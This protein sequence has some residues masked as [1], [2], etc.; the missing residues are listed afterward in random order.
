MKKSQIFTLRLFSLLLAI[1][2]PLLT[3]ASCSAEA[4]SNDQINGLRPG[5][6]Y[7]SSDPSVKPE[8]GEADEE[9]FT[10]M[11]GMIEPSA[12]SDPN[13]IFKEN[14]F[15]KVAQSPISTFSSD[16]DTAS[17]AYF[18]KLVNS[19]YSFSALTQDFGYSIRTEE[20]LNYFTYHYTEPKEG[21]LFGIHTEIAPCPWN[22]DNYLMMINFT[23]KTV[24]AN[25]NGNNLVFLID[26]SGSMYSSD[27]L[28]L[29]K[30]A[31]T[32][33]VERLTER[34]RISIVTYSGKE[35][36]VLEGCPGND[37]DTIL[38]AINSLS[39]N[40][41]TN[42]QAGIQRAYEIA[43]S[44]RIEGGNNRILMASDGDLNVGI[45]S[46]DALT[47]F[48]S[49]KRD[50]GIYLSVLGF[51]TGNYQD[52]K[53]EA[54]ADNGDG[55]YYYIDGEHEAERIFGE[56]L[57]ST[58]YTV[59]E[60]VKLQITFA[61]NAID[62]Y[63]LIGYE[64]RMLN[65]EDFNDDKKDAGE[66]GSGHTLT[67]CYEL[68]P[69]SIADNEEAPSAFLTL[70]VR[71]KNPGESVSIL[72]EYTYG[73]ESLAETPS[74]ELRFA[75]AI[76]ETA[77]LLHRSQYLGSVTLES[78][79]GYLREINFT[80]DKKAEFKALLEKAYQRE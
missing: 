27:K 53:M 55:V 64:N 67:V 23:A 47:A 25:P 79:I 11:D 57:F 7:T 10:D 33:L 52:E 51:G 74:E 43:E 59:A 60:D 29:L 63:R 1:L 34:D 69:A 40:G 73:R 66:I 22:T 77:M 20:M 16:V 36:V 35:E 58:L 26:V 13:E 54:L 6:I 2:L 39:A 46:V 50:S 68:V 37:K 75:A 8:A 21:E 42:G 31:F 70:A 44:C 9:I 24:E 76:I 12:P 62:S 18:R 38:R 30:T 5:G 28:P 71:Y 19:G 78:V 15:V 80:D 4:P 49:E 3:L 65:T 17:Y 48:I 14:R 56:A 72:R 45:S 32:Y 61:E 41:S